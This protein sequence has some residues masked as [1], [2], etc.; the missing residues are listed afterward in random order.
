M[1]SS[2]SLAAETNLAFGRNRADGFWSASS[3]TPRQTLSEALSTPLVQRSQ[4]A[5]MSVGPEPATELQDLSQPAEEPQAF[6]PVFFAAD[7]AVP[8]TL[9]RGQV[10]AAS[11]SKGGV[12]RTRRAHHVEPV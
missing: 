7:V 11:I 4:T 6:E 5:T 10:R 8:L 1:P 3:D 2:W 9:R 12:L